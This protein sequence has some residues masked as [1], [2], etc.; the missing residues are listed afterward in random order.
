M[1]VL[2]CEG[3]T[4]VRLMNR[5]LDEGLLSFGIEEVF[6][7]KPIHARQLIEFEA[8]LSIVPFTTKIEILRI[9]DTQRDKL[10]LDHFARRVSDGLL[11][12][13]KICTKPEVEILGIIAMGWKADY[14]KT[15]L[16]PKT[17]LRQFHPSFDFLD[18]LANGSIAAIVSAIKEYKQTKKHNKDEGY[19]VD[20]LR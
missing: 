10:N 18:F 1:K 4:E 6:D 13:Q 5:L 16:R 11:T 7:H 2:M 15:R 17:Y 14:E 12:V 9:G 20:L 8:Q 19:L 3:A